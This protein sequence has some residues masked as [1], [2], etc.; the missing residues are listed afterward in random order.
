MLRFEIIESCKAIQIYADADG[1]LLLRIALERVTE[2]RHLHVRSP[3]N[4][5][6]DLNDTNPWGQAAV[7]EGHYYCRVASL[8]CRHRP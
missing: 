5:G 2:C 1:L 7:G 4:G 8:Q 6:N 3:P